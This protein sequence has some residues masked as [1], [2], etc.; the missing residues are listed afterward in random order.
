M[1]FIYE[2]GKEG[3]KNGNHRPYEKIDSNGGSFPP[4]RDSISQDSAF[5]DS[6]IGLCLIKKGIKF[7]NQDVYRKYYR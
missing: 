7:V 3:K 6:V 4:R 1:V 5:Q 2:D